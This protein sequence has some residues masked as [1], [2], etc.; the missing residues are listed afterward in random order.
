MV[1]LNFYNAKIF[2]GLNIYKGG[3]PMRKLQKF[4]VILAFTLVLVMSFS[5]L[6]GCKGSKTASNGTRI[7]MPQN[8]S[9]TSHNKTSTS[10]KNV[11]NHSN[12]RSSN[13]KNANTANTKSNSNQSASKNRNAFM[14]TTAH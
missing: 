5:G 13:S 10:N 6:T 2:L 11:I 1:V 7:T 8:T 9:D 14:T 4:K 12:K 3:E